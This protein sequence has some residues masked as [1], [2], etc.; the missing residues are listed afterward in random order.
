MPSKEKRTSL[1]LGEIRDAAY[2]AEADR[3]GIT[4]SEL[5]ILGGDKLLPKEVRDT[6]PKRN[7]P[8]RPK[9]ETEE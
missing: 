3:R 6:L 2:R 8:G 1:V 9:K 4:V 5:L 7:K